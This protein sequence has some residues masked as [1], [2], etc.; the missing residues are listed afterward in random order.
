[1]RQNGR[2]C[3]CVHSVDAPERQAMLVRASK[4]VGR[5]LPFV[6]LYQ[7][8]TSGRPEKVSNTLPGT[9]NARWP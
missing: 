1:M 2:R 4:T 6:M 8:M 5:E 7:E 3:W 9:T